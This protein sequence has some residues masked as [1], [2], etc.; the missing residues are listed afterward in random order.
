MTLNIKKHTVKE[1]DI[2]KAIA[3]VK[4]SF[5]IEG[6]VPSDEVIEISRKHLMGELSEGEALKKINEFIKTKHLH[7]DKQNG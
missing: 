3:N 2:E 5:A 7:L 4:A 1:Q 6:L